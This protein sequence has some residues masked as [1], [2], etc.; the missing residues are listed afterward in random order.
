MYTPIVKYS[1]VGEYIRLLVLR[2][3][4]EGSAPVE[5]I[6]KIVQRAVEMLGIKYDWRVWPRL[7]EGEV[8]VDNGVAVITPRGLWVLEQTAEEVAEYVRRWLGVEI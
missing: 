5:D 8:E 4:R 3:L 7:V 6:D 1:P 2:R